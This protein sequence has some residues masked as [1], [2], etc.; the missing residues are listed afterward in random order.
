MNVNDPNCT[1]PANEESLNLFLAQDSLFLQLVSERGNDFVEGALLGLIRFNSS[2]VDPF[3]TALPNTGHGIPLF[4]L[5]SVNV[6]YALPSTL[7]ICILQMKL[8]P[9]DLDA[10]LVQ[11]DD[12]LSRQ[13]PFDRADSA[14]SGMKDGVFASVIPNT[15]AAKPS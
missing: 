12:V 6:T 9:H 10:M 1:A 3:Y 5:W 11:P 14:L 4:C 7:R 2:F 13:G 15:H 8:R